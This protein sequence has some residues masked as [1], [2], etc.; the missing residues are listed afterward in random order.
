MAA[1]DGARLKESAGKPV[2]KVLEKIS[3]EY[4]IAF[5]LNNL[6]ALNIEQA[7]IV[8]GREGD[9]I[10]NALGDCYKSL[11]I[12][13]VEQS[14]QKGLMHAFSQA[15]HYIDNKEDILLQLA[16]EVFIDLKTKT[17]KTLMQEDTFDFYC[18]ITYESD[19]NKIKNN[20]SV[21]LKEDFVIKSC[22][23]KPTIVTNAM[24]G[25]G[26][27]LFRSGALEL[28][29]EAYNERKNPPFDLCDFMN[30][31]IANNKV[32]A[33][34]QVAEKEFNINTLSDLEEAKLFL[35]R[36]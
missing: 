34:F 6:I 24:K 35:E 31:L 33:V 21:E 26:F 16:D 2:C 36:N 9:L 17:I 29:K 25:T 5:A 23:E 11:K 28:L 15:L 12:T 8:V 10:K 7:F 3:G 1:G 4:L 18:G 20:F 30:A 14:C 27:C 22:T 19:L 13:Y 32:G